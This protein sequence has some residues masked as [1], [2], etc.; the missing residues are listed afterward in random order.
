VSNCR[1]CCRGDDVC[2]VA[3]AAEAF[4]DALIGRGLDV[5]LLLVVVA[6]KLEFI[7][8]SLAY[9]ASTFSSSP[10][11]TFFCSIL[12]TCLVPRNI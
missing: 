1:C 11:L 3:S 8:A 7:L 6:D 2:L 12:Q 10:S 9:D 4:G 5:L